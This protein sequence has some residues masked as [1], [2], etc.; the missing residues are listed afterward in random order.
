MNSTAAIY[1]RLSNDQTVLSALAEYQGAPAI[2][3]DLAP[4][5]FDF[6]QGKAVIVIA[7]PTADEADDT[8]TERAR[9]VRQEVRLYIRRSTSN[10]DFDSLCRHVRDL[11]HLQPGQLSVT[12]G[13]V[14]IATATGPVA[15]PTSDTS[16]VGRRVSLRLTLQE[17]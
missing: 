17:N 12:G 1:G 2:F 10:A 14:T 11:F 7:A 5:A 13:K 4:D 16:L 6:E 3:D 15:A 9:A 8:F